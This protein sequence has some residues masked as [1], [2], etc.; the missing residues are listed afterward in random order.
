MRSSP[1][2]RRFG[3]KSPLILAAPPTGP[4]W[5]EPARCNVNIQNL[6]TCMMNFLR[7]CA[8]FSSVR[9]REKTGRGSWRPGH[10]E[11]VDKQLNAGIPV[12]TD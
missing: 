2:K 7:R 9:A 10:I 1:G 6:R 12:S 8:G 5:L 3:S 4:L 11:D